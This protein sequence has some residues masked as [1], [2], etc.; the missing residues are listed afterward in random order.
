MTPNSPNDSI[1]GGNPHEEEVEEEDDKLAQQW[2]DIKHLPS[3]SPKSQLSAKI[4]QMA[5]EKLFTILSKMSGEKRFFITFSYEFI[6][7]YLYFKGYAR[8]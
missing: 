8:M 7:L 2:K 5:L 1:V 3:I 6:F 4:I